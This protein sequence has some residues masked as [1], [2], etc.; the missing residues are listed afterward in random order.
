MVVTSKAFGG[1]HAGEGISMIVSEYSVA[2]LFV[3]FALPCPVVEL[4]LHLSPNEFSLSSYETK[5]L[6]PTLLEAVHHLCH[7]PDSRLTPCQPCREV[8]SVAAME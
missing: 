2:E 6:L 3:C 4:F 7:L 5:L 8:P 1:I